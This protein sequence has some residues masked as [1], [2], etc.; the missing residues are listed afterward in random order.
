MYRG[1]QALSRGRARRF[2]RSHGGCIMSSHVYTFCVV[3]CHFSSVHSI[4]H[5]V[6]L[7]G[8]AQMLRR[9][10][11]RTVMKAV[12]H[13]MRRKCFVRG[14]TYNSVSFLSFLML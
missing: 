7:S 2:R 9:L 3:T 4:A 14:P 5:P 10:N 13:Q 6:L 11:L 8:V 12:M 1:W